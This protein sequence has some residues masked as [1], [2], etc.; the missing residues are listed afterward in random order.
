MLGMPVL[1]S[2]HGF[3]RRRAKRFGTPVYGFKLL[4]YHIA[5]I[6]LARDP[7]AFMARF[8]EEGWRFLWIRRNDLDAAISEAVVQAGMPRFLKAGEAAP[9]SLP[10]LDPEDLLERIR[11]RR[12]FRDLEAQ[13][14]AHIPHLAIRYERDLMGA[15]AQQRTVDAVADLAGVARAPVAARLS[16]T[17][18]PGGPPPIANLDEVRRRLREAGVEGAWL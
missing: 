1:T 6:H 9:E 18:T 17:V 11:R 15:E 4:S 14:M 12:A 13:I 3:I 8:A 16:K 7:G 10:R 2:P 5:G